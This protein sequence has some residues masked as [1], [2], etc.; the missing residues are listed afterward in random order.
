MGEQAE[1]SQLKIF[2]RWGRP[3]G[4]RLGLLVAAVAFLYYPVLTRL[5][6]DW[7]NDPEASH[8]PLVPAFSL[9][10]VWHRQK[11]WVGLPAKPSGFGLVVLLGSLA[12]LA[13]G[14]LG[15]EFFVARSSFVFLLA[16]LILWFLGWKYLQAF[17]FPWGFLFLMIPIPSIIFNQITFPLQLLASNFSA[18]ALE[19]C[20]IPVLREGNVIHLA[21][22]TLEVAEACSGIRSLLTLVTLAIIYGYFLETRISRRIIFA[23]VAVPIAVIAN[24]LRVF[25][26]G[27]LAHSWSQEAAEGFFH[28]FSGWLIFVIAML[29]LF[30]VDNLLRWIDRLRSRF[31]APKEA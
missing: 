14:V 3:L 7:W 13:T 12:M 26:T 22:T 31:A 17:I 29:L 25:G 2:E 15:V 23:V 10:V 21:R 1:A 30:S 28:T 19:L 9:F 8:G 24:G 6:F 5:A 4:L 18:W 27:V 11:Q 20:G 16:G